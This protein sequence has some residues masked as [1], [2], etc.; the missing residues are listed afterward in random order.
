MEG[1]LGGRTPH[2]PEMEGPAWQAHKM[3]C[4]WQ[5]SGNRRARE[6]AAQLIDTLLRVP[7]PSEDS[8]LCGAA[9]TGL[10]LLSAATD[11]RPAWNR[12]VC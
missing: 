11:V 7:L 1:H 3:N 9:G 4:A 6:E 2:A 5:S 10:V 8:F 12:C